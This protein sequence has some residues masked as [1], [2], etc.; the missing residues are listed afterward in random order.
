MSSR[1]DESKFKVD[2]IDPLFAVAIHI[3]FVEGL[4][5]ETWLEQ[6]SWPHP[7]D[8]PNLAMFVVGLCLLVSSWVG[9]HH[10]ISLKWIRGSARF[11]LDVVLLILYILLLVYFERVL[12]FSIFMFAVF[13]VYVA[14]DYF[15]TVEWHENFYDN[16]REATVC[17]YL[18]ECIRLLFNPYD[19]K[20]RLINESVSL[21]WM[22]F[23][24]VLSVWSYGI[25]GN[26]GKYAFAAVSCAGL[27]AYR[28]DKKH[29]GRLIRSRTL[30]TLVLLALV[31]KVASLI[32][33]D[34]IYSMFA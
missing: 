18:N 33:G 15:K 26:N 19:V 23:F 21:G 22:L 20:A 32:W 16:V 1:Q 14:W 9:Y 24:F 29:K 7:S 28:S 31:Y 34:A 27:F 6:R 5:R 12:F 2:F 11:I 17:S 30:Q 4:M 25:T 10:S 3:G 13:A 8:W